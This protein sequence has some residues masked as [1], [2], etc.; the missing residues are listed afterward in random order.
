MIYFH[1][2]PF[3]LDPFLLVL[4]TKQSVPRLLDEY[5]VLTGID[6]PTARETHRALA[7]SLAA[8]LTLTNGKSESGQICVSGGQAYS[9]HRRGRD[10]IHAKKASVEP[11]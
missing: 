2:I 5:S 8:R 9:Q 6:G 7:L 3:K 11:S 1:L 4:L 10:T